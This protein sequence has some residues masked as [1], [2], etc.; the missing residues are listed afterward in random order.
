MQNFYSLT[1]MRLLSTVPLFLVLAGPSSYAQ[2]G[3]DVAS[4]APPQFPNTSSPLN[5]NWNIAGNRQKNQFPL[6]SLYL[7]VNGSQ[8]IA[9][10]DY[11]AV[12][13]NSLRDGSGA[14][15]GGLH[16]KIAPDGSFTLKNSP[17]AT[18]QVEISGHVPPDG[19]TS[20]SGEYTLTGGVSSKCPNYR[21]TNSFTATPLAPLNG[22]FS[23]S[24]TM[25]YFESPSPAYTGPQSY[26]AKFR[27]TATQGAVV[28][29]RLT[30]GDVHF[31]LPLTGTIHVKGSPCFSHGV[32]D[33]LTYST[34]GSVPSR[35]SSISGDSVNMW[36]AM[37]DESQ[38]HVIAVFTDPG[39]SALLMTN[40]LV[41]GGKCD[42][43][44]FRGTLNA[45]K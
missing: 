30:T 40:A 33:P 41:I 16:G 28:A 35:Y 36:F 34:H 24:L 32:A 4:T 2:S 11:R 22:T 3:T 45:D 9:S 5:G 26:D 21:Q 42:H 44:S 29:Q 31:H 18:I 25:K 8:I 7:Q 13:P 17:R 6:L 1:N 12:C 39:E 23:G 37:N 20:W 19:A 27:I 14:I 15:G 10:G 38:L 43:Q